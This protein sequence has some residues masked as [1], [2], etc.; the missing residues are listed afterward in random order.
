MDTE[1]ERF[2]PVAFCPG[3]LR[4]LTFLAVVGLSEPRE[5]RTFAGL[6]LQERLATAKVEPRCAV[7][8]ILVDIANTAAATA[9]GLTPSASG[10][11]TGIATAVASIVSG[12]NEQNAEMQAQINK[13]VTDNV[14]LRAARICRAL[15]YPRE[16]DWDHP[17]EEGL[18]IL[19]MRLRRCASRILWRTRVLQKM[20]S[21]A[22]GIGFLFAARL[23]SFHRL[24]VRSCGD[25]KG[26]RR[27]SPTGPIRWQVNAT[28]S[29][30]RWH[31]TL[32]RIRGR[33]QADEPR[34]ENRSLKK[35]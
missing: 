1:V 5:N 11:D 31:S 15:T 8:V 13:L 20:D 2:E 4:G 32:G 27:K 9:G 34:N 25:R 10:V 18:S 35:L 7:Y 29:A 17:S 28:H 24:A 21:K 19:S 33:M 12:A 14:A 23:A 16:R 6:P 3:Y 30:A 22:L 26:G